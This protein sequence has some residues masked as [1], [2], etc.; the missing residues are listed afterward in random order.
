[1]K[2]E[3]NGKTNMK[4]LSQTLQ[5]TVMA[6]VFLIT[7][8][9][10]DIA[11]K[12]KQN[13]MTNPNFAY[14]KTVVEDSRKQ[15]KAALD[16]GKPVETLR[17]FMN[18]SIASSM[19]SAENVPGLAKELDSIVNF[20]DAPYNAIGHL[21]LAEGYKNI[22]QQN[23]HTFDQR[24]VDAGLE[25]DNP[26][27]WDRDMFARKI[28]SLVW[29]ALSEKGVASATPLSKI[30]PLITF[31][32]NDKGFTVYDFIV[33][34][35]IDLSKAV[36]R[37]AI[38]PF[39]N[40][41]DKSIDPQKLVDELM[42][43]HPS[44][45]IARNY[46]VYNKVNLMQGEEEKAS[47]LWEEIRNYGM[48]EEAVS[49]LT[50][51]FSN[52]MNERISY[53]EAEQNNLP[54]NSEDFYRYT[55]KLKQTQKNQQSRGT[56]NQILCIM[57]E[58]K[59]EFR[60]PSK[61]MTGRE[62]D[63]NFTAKNIDNFYI[64]LIKSEAKERDGLTLS[65]MATMMKTVETRHIEITGSIPFTSSDSLTFKIEQPGIYTFIASRSPRIQD[66]LT[67]GTKYY[68]TYF[69]VSDIDIIALNE[70]STGRKSQ[71]V[72]RRKD[73]GVF[74]VDA[75][76]G[77]PIEG[78]TVK[79]ESRPRYWRENK[80]NKEEKK[81]TDAEGLATTYLASANITAEFRGSTASS[82]VYSSERDYERADTTIRFYP[83]RQVYR[84]GDKMK[85]FGIV[86][87]SGNQ[88]GS[89]IS[90]KILKVRLLD[91]NWQERDSLMLCSDASG[92]IFGE[93]EIPADGLLGTWYL[94]GLGN[95]YNIEVAEYKTPSF[96][97]TLEK[98][99][100]ESPESI[101]FKGL[102]STYSGMPVA[103]AK[104]SYKVDY[105]PFHYWWSRGHDNEEFASQ[106]SSD[107]KGDFTIELPTVNLN[108]KD[109]PGVFRIQASA[110]DEAG[111]SIESPSLSF[112]LIETLRIDA[113]LP[114]RLMVST[115]TI[116]VTVKV[117]D[118]AGLPVVRPVEYSI[119]DSEGEIVKSG[120]FESP[121]LILDSAD[122]P[123]GKYELTFK[124]KEGIQ[125]QTCATILYRDTDSVPPI[126][127]ALWVPQTQLVSSAD[128]AKTAIRVGSSF[129][130]QNLLFIVSDSDGNEEYFW[131]VADGTMQTIEIES[132]QDTVRKYV[133]ICAYR[134][135]EFNQQDVT[136]IPAAQL[137]KLE[138]RTETFRTSIEPG[139]DE[140]WKFTVIYGGKPMESYAYA[141]MYDKAMDAIM[142]L[143]WQYRLFN[144]VYNRW[145]SIGGSSFQT[146]SEIF[147]I[148][149]CQYPSYRFYTIDYATYGYPLFNSLRRITAYPMHSLTR[150]AKM[151]MRP[152]LAS[153]DF[154]ESVA[155]EEEAE[156]SVMVQTANYAKMEVADTGAVEEEAIEEGGTADNHE[157]YREM[158]MPV[159]FFRPDLA[160]DADGSLT[161]AF[162]VPNF[163]T[164]WKLVLGAYTP[165]LSTANI[166]LE[167]VAAKK[168]MVKMLPPRFLRTGDKADI[169][170]TVFN[171]SDQSAE[172]TTMFEVFNPLTGA[173]IQQK[174]VE[175]PAME[176]NSSKVVTISYDC[177]D[178]LDVVGLRIFARTANSSDGEQTV[179]P[180]LPSSQPIIESHPFYL[181]PKESSFSMKLPKL[182]KDAS[183]TFKYT[184]NPIWEVVTALTPIAEPESESLT[185]LVCALYS[186]SVGLGLISNYPDIKR[187][188]NMIIEGKA[189]DGLLQSNLTK[190]ADLKTVTLNNTPWVN[191]A[192][193]E[194]LRLSRL[195]SLLD[196]ESGKAAIDKIWKK[197]LELRN[198]DGGWSWCRGMES[199]SWMTQ[200]L[201]V[202]LA[203]LREGGYLQ[204]IEDAEDC[205]SQAAKFVENA[206]TQDYV[207][208]EGSKEWFYTSLIPYLFTRSLLGDIYC[209]PSF[210]AIKKEALNYLENNWEKLPL[211][212]K[213]TLAII[214]WRDGRR[215][216]ARE[217][218]MSVSQFASESKEKGVWFDNLDSSFNG[219]G[220]LLTTSRILLAFNEINPDDAIIDRIRQWMIIQKQAQDWQEGLWS[221]D[222]IEAL[223]RTGS[224][225]TRPAM[226]PVIVVG[227]EKIATDEIARLTGS[228]TVRLT[229]GQ[230]KGDI[231]ISRASSSPAWGGVIS[232]YI[233]PMEEVKGASIPDLSIRK[234]IWKIEETEEG[235]T[236]VKAD[237]FTV[238]DK[239]RVSLI[240]DCG[241]D[242]DYVALTD[243][244]PACLEP[245][246]QLSGYD[247]IDG[248]WCYHETRNSSTN[249][250]FNF[251]QRGRHVV[252]YECRVMEAGE[253][254][255][256]VATLQCQ[257]S[258]LLTAH[259]A[260]AV[261][262][263]IKD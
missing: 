247:I 126:K 86:Y 84:P 14:P 191:N 228:V 24:T 227:K 30:S 80:E 197:I 110:T 103:D 54:V 213:A 242:M 26:Q 149:R 175:G 194:N 177:P 214:L 146:Y 240:I 243:E 19:I 222:A 52:F 124:L 93:F 5:K 239:V 21:L 171:N 219:A 41:K 38:I 141:L 100:S 152:S 63:M 217:I 96:F 218:M 119:K 236:A 27:F 170:A 215:M 250:F 9:F 70:T 73:S 75:K 244:R 107:N 67:S 178:N 132:P 74:V 109:Y 82:S 165:E 259:S 131:K 190:D 89:V 98:T 101:S 99:T 154:N 71:E 79:F 138:I 13:N 225:W 125:T 206:Y 209:I 167:T 129:A 233:A 25:N 61:T 221:I 31:K 137:E 28:D 246:D 44:P 69:E 150:G 234:E 34:K 23:Q 128:S 22:Y 187:G 29:L 203:L 117:L 77:A 12:P 163:N 156:D 53:G 122:F 118:N 173:T 135:H 106:V 263:V 72:E 182:D 231:S 45:S 211:F 201:L 49:L 50:Y 127:T 159:A 46:A 123:S 108:A 168:V 95:S 241:R 136:I 261:V 105:I 160:T 254:A 56:L 42:A 32:E 17:A 81:L 258:P 208:L 204:P 65:Q 4:L 223:L 162:K 143:Q 245:A 66:M 164:T 184:D 158:E 58:P 121:S 112:W 91:A 248:L 256:G 257:Y 212:T 55:E 120:E 166:Q 115:D 134:D 130:G 116:G 3:I 174:T 102:V 111:E 113:S 18:L 253:F 262:R 57:G 195:G 39:F 145:V 147:R 85:F 176:P 94:Q 37:K 198:S 210:K 196:E 237:S 153:V 6:A 2:K 226:Q 157:E 180:V 252:T 181:A 151:S 169:T 60:F 62:T 232:Q 188:L 230:S 186:N 202:N 20:L 104:V 183:V 114:E 35:S 78:A 155:L 33:Y 229:A 216:T 161:L 48:R 189:D 200:M 76:T 235:T 51:Y 11:A 260:G 148:N 90:S 205:M 64:L 238:G 133:T 207:K 220:K 249:L 7:L 47:L 43:L 139:A 36:S 140:E 179:I 16:A 255:S 40:E 92:R 185:S 142:P 83:D 1:M 88:S 97:I 8:G 15:M 172:V 10:T 199:S 224:K 144:P 251:L 87:S 68:P 59:V 192:E 193:S